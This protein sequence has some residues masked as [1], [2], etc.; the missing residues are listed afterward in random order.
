MRQV[1]LSHARTTMRA[2]V[3]PM[4]ASTTAAQMYSPMQAAS[5][6]PMNLRESLMKL[7]WCSRGYRMDLRL[8]VYV[9]V[10]GRRAITCVGM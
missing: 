8:I 6:T 1:C 4:D 10:K 2:G 9:W 7:S 3:A 5:M